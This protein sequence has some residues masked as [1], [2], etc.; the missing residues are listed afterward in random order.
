MGGHLS[1]PVVG[2]IAE[3]LRVAD[4]R[5]LLFN[6]RGV[7]DSDGDASGDFDDALAD[8]RAA[9]AVARGAGEVTFVAGY[10]FG[11]AAAIEV[12][13]ES[14]LSA[15]A[16]APPPA[17]LQRTAARGAR[18]IRVIAGERDG[19][20]NASELATLLS[21]VPGASVLVVPNADHFFSGD[22]RAIAELVAKA[23]LEPLA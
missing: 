7:G 2:A 10:S 22:L 16:V 9:L 6:F 8:Y 12:A 18:S 1:N 19:I 15:I 3:G 11:G 5:A 23:A 20:A 4:C 21:T 17:L 14:A 13:E